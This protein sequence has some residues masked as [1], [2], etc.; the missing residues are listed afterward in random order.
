M[1]AIVLHGKQD[2][3]YTTDY[4][5]PTP[6]PGEV[7]LRMTYT[8]ICQTDIEMWQHGMFNWRGKP[9]IQGHEAAGIVVELGEGAEAPGI[10]IGTRVAVENVRTCGTCFYCRKGTSQLCE[11]GRNFGFSDDGGLAEFG[12][13]P[14]SLCIPLPHN[15]TNEE[16]PLAEPTSVAVHAVENANVVVGEIAAVI[17]CGVVGLCTL[18]VLKAAGL[19]VI[20]I[21][22]REQS[23]TIASELGADA[24]LDPTKVDVGSLLPI[25]ADAIRDGLDLSSLP[26]WEGARGWATS[27]NVAT[28]ATNANKRNS[29]IGPDVIIETA[30]APTTATDAANWVR[31][32]GRVVIVGFSHQDQDGINFGRT[33]MGEKTIMGSS[34]TSHEGYR[35]AVSLIASGAV[36]VKPLISAQVPLDRGIEDGFERMLKPTKDVYRILVGNG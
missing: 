20:A 12:V 9:H 15:M 7:L 26:E 25:I 5:K 21:D 1:Q 19:K 4:P 27:D 3:R 24:V 10:E 31:K 33:H 23:L 32:G 18:Q 14:A 2:I 6:G 16:A 36:N 13:W 29:Y 22:P 30:G 35:K 28:P 11:N 8:S 34:A 17:G